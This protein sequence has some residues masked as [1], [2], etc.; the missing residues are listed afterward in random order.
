[1]RMKEIIFELNQLQR[2]TH[3]HT[4]SQLNSIGKWDLSHSMPNK[5]LKN[6][7]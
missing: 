2:L 5:N 1:M 4:G 3:E 6:V 7:G